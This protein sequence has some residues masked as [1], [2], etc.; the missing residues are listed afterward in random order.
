MVFRL[1]LSAVWVA[2]AVICGNDWREVK[3][4]FFFW[5]FPCFPIRSGSSLIVF[6]TLVKQLET[7]HGHVII[8]SAS[9]F[10]GNAWVARTCRHSWTKSEW[11]KYKINRTQMMGYCFLQFIFISNVSFIGG[12]WFA[13]IQRRQRIIRTTCMQSSALYS[14]LKHASIWITIKKNTYFSS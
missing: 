4:D 6:E 12:A 14:H 7:I 9:S 11:K 13:W 10:S 3:S 5:A 8:C 2:S 1:L